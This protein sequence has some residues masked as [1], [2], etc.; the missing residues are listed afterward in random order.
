MTK[1]V[2]TNCVDACEE[3][4]YCRRENG[5]FELFCTNPKTSWHR[6]DNIFT[7]PSWCELQDLIDEDTVE[8]E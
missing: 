1:I 5:S 4:L 7:I 8:I 6:I 3:C 2:P